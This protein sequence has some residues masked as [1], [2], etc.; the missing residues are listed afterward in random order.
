MYRDAPPEKTPARRGCSIT[1]KNKTLL[2]IIDPVAQAEKTAAQVLNQDRTLYFCP[3]PLLGYGL[4]TLLSR[5]GPG[6]AVL[7]VETDAALLDLSRSSM[8]GILL[9]PRL[10]LTG[11]A[12]GAEL[13][14]LVRQKWGARVFRRVVM[15]KFSGGWQLDSAVY[16]ALADFLRRDIARQW[17]NA[18]TLVKL[19]RRFMRNVLRNLAALRGSRPMG[20]LHFGDKPVLVLGAGPSLDPLLDRLRR[21]SVL[22]RFPRPF[23]VVCVD[24]CLGSLGERGI[25]P[26]LAVILESQFWN[27]RDFIGRGH[28]QIPAALDLSAYP[29]SAE[30]LGG[31]VYFFFTPWTSLRI[32]DRIQAAGLLPPALPPLG[33]VGLTAVELARRLST[34]EIITAGIDFSFTMDR[35]HARSSPNHLASLTAQ[36]RLTGL[37]NGAAVFRPGTFNV[38]SKTNQ[39]VRSDP[40]M[41]TYRSLFEQEFA[42]DRRIRDV[43]GTGLPLGLQTLTVEEAAQLLEGG[44]RTEVP[45]EGAPGDEISP[46]KTAQGGVSHGGSPAE[47]SGGSGG[48]GRGLP[49]LETLV[50]REAALLEELRDMLTGAVNPGGLDALLDEADYLWA[51]FPDCAGTQ[52]RRPPASDLGFLK[53]VRAEIDLFLNRWKVVLSLLCQV[54]D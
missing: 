13:C 38:P 45:Q 1:Y 22:H 28:T 52:G 33:S 35:T 44:G 10:V 54:R 4:E 3:S 18:M 34:G 15:V 27:Q 6:S 47:D 23:A 20:G 11:A 2:S 24:T 43:A 37:I 39:P 17:G 49:E 30:A 14:R 50:R 53:R 9:H 32:F 12:D 46:E 31:P 19:G 7:C 51:H 21:S 48:E 40:A 29:S 5:S 8:G 16:D 36:N 26:D 25:T 41:R 42:P